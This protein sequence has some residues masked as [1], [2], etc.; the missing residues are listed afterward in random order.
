MFPYLWLAGNEGTKKD[1]ETTMG[2]RVEKEW[3][4]T[5]KLPKWNGVIHSRDYYKDPFLHS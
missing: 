3:K 5:W 4:G 2:F 1:M